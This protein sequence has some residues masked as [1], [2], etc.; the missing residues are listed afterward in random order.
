MLTLE[1]GLVGA[2]GAFVLLS[3]FRARKEIA[4]FERERAAL[5][6]FQF[7][8]HNIFPVGGVQ[9]LLPDVVPPRSRPPCGLRGGDSANR[10]LEI[11]A[12]PGGFFVSLID[13]SEDQL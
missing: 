1:Q 3:C 6:T 12:M 10:L 4:A 9:G 2:P 11:G 7:S 5:P 8:A 13:Q